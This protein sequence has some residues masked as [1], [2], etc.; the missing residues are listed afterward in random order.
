[1]LSSDPT[2]VIFALP[3][4]RV[5]PTTQGTHNP[6]HTHSAA[7]RAR[8]WFNAA[9]APSLDGL[10][11]QSPFAAS[12]S[13]IAPFHATPSEVQGP[14]QAT[15]SPDAAVDQALSPAP[16]QADQDV[17]DGAG[18]CMIPEASAGINVPE[19]VAGVADNQR[20]DV[21][22]EARVSSPCP[23]PGD[24]GAQA[25]QTP[26]PP[27]ACPSPG[28]VEMEVASECVGGASGVV[29]ADGVA[30]EGLPSP[31]E[32]ADHSSSFAFD[33]IPTAHAPSPADKAT[34]AA[35]ETPL[36]STLL[37]P[38]P[39]AGAS[40]TSAPA[41]SASSPTSS[42]GGPGPSHAAP[43]SLSLTPA[44]GLDLTGDDSSDL[45]R[46]WGFVPGADDTLALNLR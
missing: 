40:P 41:P 20:K 33:A 43:A 15:M 10:D 23:T 26:L 12:D 30:D 37:S 2:P 28:D 13:A 35:A 17:R 19:A 36:G 18:T 39:A 22:D 4:H 9:V 34:E 31:A 24:A 32:V 7:L 27:A 8:S 5:G 25:K 11:T 42:H 3:T 6:H 16:V 1:M 29:I 38:H 46:K 14:R 45:V 21:E 44:S